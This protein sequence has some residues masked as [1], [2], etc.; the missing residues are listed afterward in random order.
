MVEKPDDWV[1]IWTTG[2][3][4]PTPFNMS[5]QALI[6]LHLHS[7]LL[8]ISEAA[9]RTDTT[10]RW[11]HGAGASRHWISL[12]TK[13]ASLHSTP[14]V[15][16]MPRVTSVPPVS[17]QSCQSAPGSASHACRI[18]ERA[19]PVRAERHSRRPLGFEP[20]EWCSNVSCVLECDWISRPPRRD[21]SAVRSPLAASNCDGYSRALS[22]VEVH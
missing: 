2:V 11:S 8:A 6:F 3:E 15:P 17:V 4:L 5:K 14:L 22:S 7:S 10:C 16:L 20:H 9:R 18:R 21:S 1:E 13:F 19:V 12:P